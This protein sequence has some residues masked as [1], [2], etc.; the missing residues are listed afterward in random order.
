MAE[1]NLTGSLQAFHQMLQIHGTLVS[2]QIFEN[3]G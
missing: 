2:F 3:R 1:F